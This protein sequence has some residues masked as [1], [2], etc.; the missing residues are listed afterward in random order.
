[1][2]GKSGFKAPAFELYDA[3]GNIRKSSDLLSNY[4]Y[5]NFISIESFTCREDLELLKTLHN[6]H[7]ADFKVI[8]ISIDENLQEVQKY[9]DDHGFD[10]ELLS[11]SN[12]KNLIDLYRVKAY[13]TYYLI[14]PEGNLVM[15]PANPPSENFEWYFFK[16]LQSKTKSQYPNR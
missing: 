12:Q 9:F 8:S 2:Q 6:K 4:V 3:K 10:W 13:P 7:K 16:L 14:S 15:A 5:L 11:Y 1:M